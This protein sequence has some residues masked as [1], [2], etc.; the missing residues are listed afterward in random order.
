M[1][2]NFKF[3][4]FLVGGFL[5]LFLPHS[6]FLIFFCRSPEVETPDLYCCDF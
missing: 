3:L 5:L 6:E 4:E 2:M 1:M